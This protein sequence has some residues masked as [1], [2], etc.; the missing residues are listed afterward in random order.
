M[1]QSV[2]K[3][4]NVTRASLWGAPVCISLCIRFTAVVTLV[5]SLLYNHAINK[6]AAAATSSLTYKE[7]LLLLVLKRPVLAECMEEIS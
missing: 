4:G 6:S 3:G 1:T 5:F 7:H 2:Y